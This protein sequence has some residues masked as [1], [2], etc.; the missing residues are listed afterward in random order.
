MIRY[1]IKS[2]L[3]DVYDS[4]IGRDIIDKLMLQMNLSQKYIKNPITMGMSLASLKKLVGGKMDAGFLDA[5]I[6][7]LNSEP[8]VRMGAGGA[9]GSGAG[10]AGVSGAGGA[11]GSGAGSSLDAGGAGA[12]SS[13]GAGAGGAERQ[14][15]KESVFYQIYPRSFN[16]TNGDGIGDIPGI[17]EKL[18]YLHELGIDALW[19]CPIYDSPQDDNGYDIRDYR[20]IDP[21]LGTM[22]DF[23]FLLSEVHRRGMRL[24]MDLVVNHTSDEHNWF[25]MAANDPGSKYR[26]Y[27]IIRRGNGDDPPNNWN[28]FFSGSAWKRLPESDE[29]ALCLFS[30]K[31]M[32]LNWDNPEMRR[33]VYD[34]IRWWLGKG[35]DG[36]RLDVINLISKTPGLPDGNDV[37]GEMMGIRGIERYFYGPH[38]HEYLREMNSEAFEPFGAFTVGETPGIGMETGKLLT[39][40]SRRELNMMFSFDHLEMPGKSRFDEY[41]YD[42]AFL[43]SY[44]SE[45]M[46]NYSAD[47]RMSLFY[48]NHD[49][50]RMLSKIDPAGR[51]RDVLAKLLAVLQLTLRGTP[52]I[53]QGQELGAVN[54][55]FEH[56]SDL[57]DV[58]SLNLYNELVAK[59]GAEDAFR[60]VLSG[61]RDHAR[62]PMQWDSSPNGGF[63]DGEPWIMSVPDG[64]DAESLAAADGS[65]LN[66]YRR[67]IAFRKDSEALLYG[68]IDIVKTDA[69]VFAYKRSGGGETLYVEC[70]LSDGPVARPA[71][72]PGGA[73]V[74][75]NYEGESAK[76]RPYEAGIYRAG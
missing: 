75:S 59:M 35:V 67:L 2:K 47:C 6:D 38:L 56:I 45:W 51:F 58:E 76:L 63:S 70:N 9:G 44:Y 39:A 21:S 65:I 74:L 23:D 26:D 5:V 1:S 36:F 28:S 72:R 14:W 18:D 12:G 4:P 68:D 66:F 55:A 27:Y 40:D 43:K 19:L 52:F 53:Y 22:E 49:N 16:D 13:L 64:Y 50:P 8:S 69:C 37:I 15:W 41:I 7:L 48:D 32:D 20:A 29:W 54:T 42:A 57:R 24:I 62:V 31:Q 3:R 61:T 30:K 73:L 25:R 46:E 11:G 17:T 71:R 33:D 34:M 10:G 60:K